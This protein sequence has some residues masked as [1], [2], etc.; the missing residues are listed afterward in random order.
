[1][2]DY[3][4]KEQ[5]ESLEMLLE[6]ER[7]ISELYM[8]LGERCAMH[9]SFWV[10]FAAQ[11]RQHYEWIN[12]LISKVKEG[13]VFFDEKRFP[14]QAMVTFQEYVLSLQKKVQKEDI[15]CA[16]IFYMALDLENALLEKE[17]FKVFEPDTTELKQLLRRLEMATKE[18]RDR[19]R[20]ARNKMQESN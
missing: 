1:M 11:E 18:H 14:L 4:T 16:G 3:C 9:R 2:S 5:L 10:K 13:V 20:D 15:P 6:N 8:S 12:L 7:V 19:I 17:F